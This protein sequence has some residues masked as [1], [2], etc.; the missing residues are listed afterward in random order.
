MQKSEIDEIVNARLTDAEV[1][2]EASRFDGS[3]YLCGYG[4]E[5]FLKAQ[6]CKTLKWNEYPMSGKF[7][8]FRT[9]DLDVLL[10]LTGLE[11]KV[12]ADYMNE[13]ST[14]AQ[15]NP[16][17]RYKPVG[18]VSGDEAKAMLDSAKELIGKL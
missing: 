5:L 12:K 18:T 14:V 15:W 11:Q 7:S 10:Q 9:H 4:V 17:A 2:L 13:W 1:L 3:V 6:I 16:E 8:S